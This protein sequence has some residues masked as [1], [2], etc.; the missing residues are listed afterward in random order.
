[1]T[2]LI[3]RT[4]ISPF[5]NFIFNTSIDLHNKTNKV[6]FQAIDAVVNEKLKVVYFCKRKRFILFFLFVCLLLLLLFLPWHSR[7]EQFALTLD[8]LIE[9]F[10]SLRNAEVFA[11]YLKCCWSITK[12][13]NWS[14]QAESIRAKVFAWMFSYSINANFTFSHPKYFEYALPVFL[15]V[16]SPI[17]TRIGGNVNMLHC[18]RWF[19]YLLS[20]F[21]FLF[22]GLM[23]SF[24]NKTSNENFKKYMLS[25]NPG[26]I[27]RWT[28]DTRRQVN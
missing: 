14:A 18:L 28:H 9:N 24:F 7:V 13:R 15:F 22:S 4:G 27:Y 1:M 16:H 12:D 2:D 19:F 8:N 6:N 10:K 3:C 21:F 23:T 26:L 11:S 20:F 25:G 17:V 5:R